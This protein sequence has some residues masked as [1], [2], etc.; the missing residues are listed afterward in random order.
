MET[1]EVPESLDEWQEIQSPSPK[2]TPISVEQDMAVTRDN[3]QLN[4][5]SIF[6]PSHYEDLDLEANQNPNPESS[7][8][9]SISS[10]SDGDEEN[11]RLSRPQVGN[12]IRRGL[13]MRL[14]ILRTGV[15]KVASR[16][17]SYVACAG[18]FWSIASVTGVVA[19]VL[20]SFLYV[21]VQRW[22][23]AVY[24]ESKDRLVFLIREKDEK[25]SQ[26]LLHI[27]QLNE[28][29]SVRRRVPV[30]RIG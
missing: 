26:L 20:L 24:Q 21:R 3:K 13:R 6:P 12:E 9:S 25:I 2:L 4:N 29:L 5:C 28:A 10:N 7:S 16:V 1:A 11:G 8:S 27:A 17:R 22:R 14:E 15:F 30:L 18:G 23:Q 19:A